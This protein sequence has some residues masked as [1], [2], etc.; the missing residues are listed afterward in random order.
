MTPKLFAPTRRWLFARLGLFTLAEA[1]FVA[2]AATSFRDVLVAAASGGAAFVPV[3]IVFGAAAA[4]FLAGWLRQVCAEDVGMRYANDLRLM[5]ASHA[6]SAGGRRRLGTLAV[7]LTGDLNPMRDWAS[8]GISE[9]AA[10]GASLGAG[11]IALYAAANA[12]GL[13]AGAGVCALAAIYFAVLRKPLTAKLE[14]LRRSRGRV[15]SAAGDIVL[16]AGAIA[17]YDAFGRERNRMERRAAR[18]RELSVQRRKWAAALDAPGAIAASATIVAMLVLQALS[19]PALSLDK[20]ALALFGASILGAGLKQAGRAVDS[21]AAYGVAL[22][23]MN[24][25]ASQI[26]ARRPAAKPA[27]DLDVSSAPRKGAVFSAALPSG[28]MLDVGKGKVVLVCATDPTASLAAVEAVASASAQA[29]LSGRAL[30]SLEPK[31][32]A[33]RI[34]LVAPSSPLVRGSVRRNLSLRRVGTTREEMAAALRLVGLDASHYPPARRIDP[35]LGVPNDY[36]QALLRLARAITHKAK[37][38]LVA[39]PV[40]LHAPNA[41]DLYVQIALSTGA[42]VIAASSASPREGATQLDLNASPAAA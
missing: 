21:H 20:W 41:P 28:H 40:L 16:S 15:A 37:V 24:Q 5:L 25:L 19:G 9:A 38:I 23:R 29:W 26:E 35:A 42:A 1:G 27:L 36:D 39:E 4:G 7:R 34:G 13:G 31:D 10:G 18:L 2:L 22:R 30:S 12:F 17:R 32:L 11:L 33:R 8:L 6:A 3:S 14:S